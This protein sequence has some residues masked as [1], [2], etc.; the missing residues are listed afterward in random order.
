[1]TIFNEPEARAA[2]KDLFDLS[3]GNAMLLPE[4][5]NNLPKPDEADDIQ[6]V[7]AWGVSCSKQVHYI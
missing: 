5:L 2:E 7:L 3:L 4:L 1:M 6:D